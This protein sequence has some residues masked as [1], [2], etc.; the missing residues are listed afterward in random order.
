MMGQSKWDEKMYSKYSHTFLRLVYVSFKINIDL[1][2]T[3]NKNTTNEVTK[4]F[5]IITNDSITCFTIAIQRYICVLLLSF[6][7]VFA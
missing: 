7:V 6:E 5:A 3:N 1:F 2:S 4:N